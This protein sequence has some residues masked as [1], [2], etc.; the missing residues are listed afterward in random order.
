[1]TYNPCGNSG[2]FGRT[3]SLDTGHTGRHRHCEIS[4]KDSTDIEKLIAAAVEKK[5]SITNKAFAQSMAEAIVE[6]LGLHQE[7]SHTRQRRRSGSDYRY[8]TDW[9]N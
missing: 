3:C 8:V 7:Y 4:W 1:M 2:E 6:A 9:R 5:M